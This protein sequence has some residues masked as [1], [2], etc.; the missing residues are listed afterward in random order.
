MNR[1]KLDNPPLPGVKATA[2]GLSALQGSLSASYDPELLKPFLSLAK[3]APHPSE[4]DILEEATAEGTACLL[5]Q[6][7]KEEA[8]SEGQSGW[9]FLTLQQGYY[10]S[11]AQNIQWNEQFL[12]DFPR[13]TNSSPTILLKGISLL[14]TVYRNP[15]LRGVIGIPRSFTRSLCVPLSLT[16]NR[17]RRRA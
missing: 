11:L 1:Q 14:N 5:Y 2:D 12:K 6:K 3:L 9:L 10:Q 8:D 7:M 15:G 16:G 13:H 17:K 4:A